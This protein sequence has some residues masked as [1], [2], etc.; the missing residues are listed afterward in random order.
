M[1]LRLIERL[2]MGQP[3]EIENEV[4]NALG[5]PFYPYY[6]QALT[7]LDE[8]LLLDSDLHGAAHIERVCFLGL[9]LSDKLRLSN[10]DARLVLTACAFHDIGRGSD[11]LDFGHGLRGAE[12]ISRYVDLEGE[13]QRILKAAIEA[14]SE[15]D[16]KMQ[17][18]MEK[19]H[20]NDKER[21]LMI[22]RILKDADGLD[23]V[24][25]KD[26]DRGQLRFRESTGLIDLAYDL[27]WFYGR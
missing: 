1:R 14:H 27:Y 19:H 5:S 21:G 6:C 2:E 17:G 26:L 8:G 20:V 22:A 23:R 16:K 13:E 4:K 15:D 7:K 12:L 3:K 24:R 18:I 9:I 10:E 25:L 11:A